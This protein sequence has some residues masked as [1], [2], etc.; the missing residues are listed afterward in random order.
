M[1]EKKN[2]TTKIKIKIKI[3]IP[4]DLKLQNVTEEKQQMDS[5]RFVKFYV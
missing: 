5:F 4:S 3:K 1:T 2:K